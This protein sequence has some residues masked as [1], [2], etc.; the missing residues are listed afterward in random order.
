MTPD[1]HIIDLGAD[2]PSQ[3]RYALGTVEPHPTD[4]GRRWVRVHPSKVRY[5]THM[6]RI[7]TECDGDII[8]VRAND[9]VTG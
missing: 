2:R 7:V 1:L 5:S 8:T 3:Y 6:P 9:E 4:E